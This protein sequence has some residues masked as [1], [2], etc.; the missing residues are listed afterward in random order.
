MVLPS[1]I[2]GANDEI[3]F[4]ADEGFFIFK[5]FTLV[6]GIVDL[7]KDPILLRLGFEGFD[8]LRLERD[9]EVGVEPAEKA[10][11]GIAVAG[12]LGV[13][14]INTLFKLFLDHF[15]DNLARLRG[16]DGIVAQAVDHFALG[17]ENVVEL[18]EAL[19]DGEILLLN[20]L[21]CVFDRPVERGVLELFALCHGLFEDA[22]NGAGVGKE[23][24]EIVFEGDEELGHPRVSLTGAT[25]AELAVDTAGLVALRTNHEEATEFGNT[26]AKLNVGSTTCHIGGDG[27]GALL[28]STGNDLRFLRMEL[29]IEH[30]VH[31]IRALEHTGEQLGG[32]DRCGADEHGLA[33]LVRFF[34]LLNH[35]IELFAARLEDDV[36]E[37]D[38]DVRLVGRDDHDGEAVDFVKLRRFGF[39]RAGHTRELIIHAKVVLDGDRGVGLG[40]L[41]DG[42]VFLGFDRLMK[43]IRPATAGHDASSVLVDYVDLAVLH[44]VF[45]VALVEAVGTEQLTDAV[46]ALAG[47]LKKSLG[48]VLGLLFG[49][50]GKVV[51]LVD[52]D[53]LGG[54]VGQHES[55]G[56]VR[57]HQS[58]P[59]LGEVGLLLLFVDYV[60]EF[61]FERVA[62]LFVEVAV[63]LEV[64]LV[65][66]AANRGHLIE[67]VELLIF[68]HPEFDL[69]ELG[70]GFI[71]QIFARTFVIKHLL[72]I[73]NQLVTERLLLGKQFLDDRLDLIKRQGLV[74]LHRTR[75]D[76][77]RA[78]FVDQNGV[79]FVNNT[80]VVVALDLVFLAAGHAV[81][82]QVVEAELRGGA[83]GDVAVIHLAA[84]L[85]IH[86]VLDATHS[87]PEKT[88]EV[89]HPFGVAPCKVVVNSHE[90]TVAASQRIEIERAGRDEGLTLTGRHFRDTFFMQRDTANELHIVVHHFPGKLMVA[91]IV[92]IPAHA[93]GGVLHGGEGLGQQVVETFPVLLVAL[94]ELD[95]LRA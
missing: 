41:L 27:D 72:G 13:E 73:G 42:A 93:A 45:F 86:A 43:T 81:V 15:K 84:G 39:R 74:V 1:A 20:L 90:L 28:S 57:A 40:L 31:N 10:I 33:G 95:C 11:H 51:L 46:D 92:T 87:Q 76:E 89:P 77:R 6:I 26:L 14:R 17:V 56:I 7:S 91:D 71:Y 60:V 9:R 35:C 29:G 30:T 69:V 80:E 24:H 82:A 61:F 65:D 47:L 53:K 4:E 22:G 32:F 67:A 79:H 58:A 21:L 8:L 94:H 44:D 37:I 62:A 59:P 16:M 19:A 36:V 75:N 49:L 64:K 55:I 70:Y 85:G 50:R 23:T 3:T 34:D 18:E 5:L 12:F 68:R 63:H 78:G 54:E 66:G 2:Q 38:A 48:L 25:A 88:K 52:L 83:V